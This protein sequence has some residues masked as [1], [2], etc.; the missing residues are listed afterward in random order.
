MS[1]ESRS[2][3]HVI[4]HG[5]VQGVGYRAFVEHEALKRGIEGWVR[6]RADGSVEGV[7]SAVPSVLAEMVEICRVGP[8]LAHVERIDQRDGADA[9]MC[10]RRSGELFSVLPT[11]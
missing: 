2:I 4:V 8:R 3:R 5:R 6:N 1:G 7:F 11:V 9:D 10:L